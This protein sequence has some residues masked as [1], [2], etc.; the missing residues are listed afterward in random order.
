[1]YYTHTIQRGCTSIPRQDTIK[2]C[3]LLVGDVHNACQADSQLKIARQK[4]KVE[5]LNPLIYG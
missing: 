2:L 5:V 4:G 3:A 1:M